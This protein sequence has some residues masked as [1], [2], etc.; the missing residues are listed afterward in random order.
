M[1]RHQ[2][3]HE[4]ARFLVAFL[5]GDDDLVDVLGVE[6]ADRALGQRAFL[7]DQLRRHR[8]EREIAHRLPQ[9]QQIFE[10]AFDLGLGAAGAGGAQDHAH[11]LRHFQFLG[12]FL[13]PVA[14]FARGDL[15]RN[16]AAAGG[17]RHQHRIAAGEREIG[18]ERR[19]LGAALFLDHLHQHDLAALDHLLNLVLAAEARHALL[20]FLHGVGA[21]DEF[22]LLLLR[23][24][25][26]HCRASARRGRLVGRLGLGGGSARWSPVSAWSS[27]PS[28]VFGG[29]R[30]RRGIGWLDC[31]SRPLRRPAFRRPARQR[32][33]S[34]PPAFVSLARFVL[35]SLLARSRSAGAGLTPA[36][37][38]RRLL[39]RQ[40]AES[41]FAR[42]RF[43]VRLLLGG[44]AARCCTTS[45]GAIGAAVAVAI[46]AAAPVGAVIGVGIGGALVALF[47]RRAAPAG[48]RPEFD[49]SRDG[50]PRTPGSR[51]GCRRN[52][53][54]PPATTAQRA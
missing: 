30:H 2:H 44:E 29:F 39:R 26:R 31:R 16:A 6:I 38:S 43:D 48:R 40:A 34:R 47:L 54:R 27:P 17:V 41:G 37:R 3:A 24:A 25:L 10:V 53:R 51:G 50:F 1:A 42:R 49:S 21:A 33:R 46:A 8:F 19:A 23:G 22:D 45:R 52:R 28:G 20:H 36:T 13:Q 9:P 15:A 14:V 12:D 5:A 4:L 32:V 35:S 11:A 18:G 7:V